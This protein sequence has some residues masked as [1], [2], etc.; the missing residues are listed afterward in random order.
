M[1]LRNYKLTIQY[2][3]SNYAGWQIQNNA[4]TIQQTISDAIKILLKQDVNLIGSGRTDTGVHAIGQVANFRTENEIDIYKFKHSL[5][6]ILPS[7]ISIV[8]MIEVNQEFHSRFD[9]KKRSYIY[10]LSQSKSPF[11]KNYSYFYPVKVDLEKLNLAGKLFLG[12]KDFTSFT[13]KNVEVEN[14]NCTVFDLNCREEKNLI[15]FYIQANRFLH[16][17]VRAIIG[18]LLKS[19]EQKDPEKFITEIFNSHNREEASDSVPSK[20]LFLYKVEY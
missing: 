15:V 6:S 13:K 11:F 4:A 9:A 19:Q 18:T 14:K 3:G 20:G 5:N 17:M 12:E 16:G 7:D 2:D 1:D 10:L 8:E